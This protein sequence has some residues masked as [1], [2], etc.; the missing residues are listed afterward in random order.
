MRHFHLKGFDAFGVWKGDIVELVKT[1]A[2][3]LDHH[4][5]G[6]TIRNR[7]V[8][9]I[10]P[11]PL[12]CQGLRKPFQRIVKQMFQGYVQRGL[13][14]TVQIDA[15]MFPLAVQQSGRF[16]NRMRRP[17]AIDTSRTFHLRD[18]AVPVLLTQF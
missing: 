3:P 10:A 17:V 4:L 16:S 12:P 15:Y 5:A 11:Y 9:V 1:D 14:G 2:R 7:Y 6:L 13:V 18:N 8:R